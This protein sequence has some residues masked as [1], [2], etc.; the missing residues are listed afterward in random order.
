MKRLF[1]ISI[2]VMFLFCTVPIAY[3]ATPASHFLFD[4]A[5]GTITWYRGP[6]GKV[7]IPSTIKGVKVTRIGTRAFMGEEYGMGS[8]NHITSLVIPS[9]IKVIEEYAFASSHDLRT[10]VLREGITTIK[11]GAFS[12]CRKLQ[13]LTIPSTVTSIGQFTISARKGVTV[14]S[15]NRHYSSKDGVL[16]NKTKTTLIKYPALAQTTSYTVPSSVKN[17]VT[18]AFDDCRYLSRISV[19]PKIESIQKYAFLAC[20]N[21]NKVVFRGQAPSAAS[22]VSIYSNSDDLK[23]YY[24]P[25][26]K[27]WTSNPSVWM[28]HPA[29]PY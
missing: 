18:Y 25:G 23:V 2:V 21:L 12:D 1:K 24:R 19:S 20:N 14:A 4:K 3:G 8:Y 16:F 27:G 17:I 6:G 26:S 5:S 15:K 10:V 29:L 9:S 11:R 22:R 7:E 13:T 28:G